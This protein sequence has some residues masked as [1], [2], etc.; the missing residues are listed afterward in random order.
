MK[1]FIALVLAMVPQALARRLE[2]PLHLAFS[3]DEEVGCL[4]VPALIRGLPEGVA[5]PRLAIIGEP[6]EMQVATAH[7]GIHFLH[8]QVTGHEA[9]SSSPE[10]GVNAIAA[11]AEIIAEIG[12]LAGECRAVAQPDGAFDPPYTSFNIGSIAGGAAVNIIARDCAFEW[13]FRPIPGE[14]SAALQRRIDDFIH[15]RPAAADA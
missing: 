4:G 15:G 14:D 2:I 1:G 6:T 11:A 7:K 13:E 8:T 5:R 3:Y 10:H 12:R 9:H